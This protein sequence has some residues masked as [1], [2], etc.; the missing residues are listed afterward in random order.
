[1][2]FKVRKLGS[3]LGA[4]VIGLDLTQTLDGD[5]IAALLAAWSEHLILLFRDQSLTPTQQIAFSR[6]FG[7]LDDHAAIPK[8]R[9]AEHPE[10]LMVNN[11][12]AATNK[13]LSVGRQWHSDLSTTLRPAK[14]SLLHAIQLP[15]V[16]GDTMFCNMYRAWDGLSPLL[17]EWL[18]GRDAIHDM[19]IARETQ[20]QRTHAELEEIRLRN[21]RVYQ[22]ICRIHEATGKKALYVS[23]MT[24][25]QIDGLTR[26]ES[27]PILEYLYRQ[28]TV[29]ENVYRHVWRK[30]DSVLWDNRCVMHI[31]LADYDDSERRTMHRTT[32]KGSPSG[33]LV[34]A[35]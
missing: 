3:A 28:S 21:P 12:E 22:P 20:L 30:G 35:A 14:G 19:T 25:S 18:S 9:H 4:E 16:G 26:E 33:R 17:Q 10:I 29:H 11:R 27:Q 34:Q 5:T 6:Y 1:M 15:M 8:F 31:A 32:L 23:E 7:E 24:T 2:S 13:R